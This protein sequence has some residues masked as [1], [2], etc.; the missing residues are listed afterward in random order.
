MRTRYLV[1]GAAGFIAS[2]LCTR[3]LHEGHEVVG[4]DGFTD[5]YNP[6]EKLARAAALA[7]HPGFTLVPG[8][9]TDLPLRQVLEGV[10]VV[11]HLAGRAG[12]R[13]SFE[14]ESEYRRD[15]V[16]STA[17]LLE[18]SRRAPSV[19]RLVYAS[20]SSVYG[21]APVPFREDGETLP[22]S[23]YGQ[24]KLEAE[25][26]C[27]EADGP[28]LE[29]IA[30]RYFTVYGPGQRPD[31]GLR[32][33]AEAALANRPL[34]V[35]GDGSQSR[36]FTY[37]EDIIE[38]TCRAA[39]APSSGIA[40]NV[41]GGSRITLTGTLELLSGIIGRPLNLRHEPFAQGD[42]LHTGAD[43][44]RARELL[45]FAPATSLAD[46]LRAEIDWIRQLR[47]GDRSVAA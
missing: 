40:I 17:A 3:L 27:L 19:R 4:I 43:L 10:E 20:S 34:H 29:T 30:L 2:H 15:N 26:L 23:P 14:L 18:A 41:G 6:S 16:A 21:N 5:S 38:A 31:M 24:T 7:D 39:L 11:H 32:I 37:V 36:D 12:V 28:D 22:L 13:A 8:H 1:T 47:A 42:A 33:F 25:R 46:G 9:L 35:F 45:G 44:T